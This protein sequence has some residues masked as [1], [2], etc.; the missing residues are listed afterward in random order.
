MGSTRIHSANIQRRFA[1]VRDSATW[2]TCPSMQ[3]RPRITFTS[4]RPGT[5]PASKSSGDGRHHRD[6]SRCLLHQ[7]PTRTAVS[8]VSLITSPVAFFHVAGDGPASARR[9]AQDPREPEI[10]SSRLAGNGVSRASS[11]NELTCAFALSATGQR[12]RVSRRPQQ[13]A[14]PM[15]R[16]RGCHQIDRHLADHDYP[17]GDGTR[18]RTKQSAPPR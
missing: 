9:V 12:A 4:P 8:A 14:F 10:P 15:R 13:R 16:V 11:G 18:A 1:G 2:L 6:T 17:A 7:W 3:L 5:R